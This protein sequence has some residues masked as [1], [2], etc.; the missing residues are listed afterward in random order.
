MQRL[1]IL[2]IAIFP[3]LFYSGVVAAGQAPAKKGPA[4]APAAKKMTVRKP[5]LQAPIVAGAS[6]LHGGIDPKGGVAK[7]CVN[8]DCGLFDVYVS[9]AGKLIARLNDKTPLRA[10]NAVRLE[11]TVGKDTLY[12]DVVVVEGGG[13]SH[14]GGPNPPASTPPEIQAPADLAPV[15]VNALQAGAQKI[16][17]TVP[18]VSERLA[19]SIG[20]ET[21]AK[22][23]RAHV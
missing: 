12:S 16:T 15:T 9:A 3:V 1:G 7:I 17:G 13:P 8:Y 19:L 11:H 6:E 18:T 22:I 4:K 21:T 14:A 23:G 20:G 5:V 10:G 2:G